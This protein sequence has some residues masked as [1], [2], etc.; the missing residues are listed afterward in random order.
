MKVYKSLLDYFSLKKQIYIDIICFDLDAFQNFK[1]IMKILGE[2]LTNF[3]DS[4]KLLQ[5]VEIKLC[6]QMKTRLEQKTI[7]DVREW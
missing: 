2:I 5:V 1:K 3:Y 7:E 6:K 4:K